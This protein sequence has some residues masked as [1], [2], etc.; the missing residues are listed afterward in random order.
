M[1]VPSDITV[2]RTLMPCPHGDVP[3][4]PRAG[5]VAAVAG[6]A[7]VVLAGVLAASLGHPAAAQAEIPVIGPVIHKIG[8]IGHTILHPVD[9]V[10]EG[11]LKILQ[12]IFGGIE[13]RLIA[14]VINALLT[15]PNFD[16]GHVAELEQTTVAIAA[17]MLTAVLTLSILR[18]YV[19]GLT[20]SGSGG[21]EALQGVVRVIGAVGFIIL[22]PGL[23][24]E[25]V[26][27]PRL[28]NEALLGSG[29]VQ[30]NVA[31]LFDAALVLGAGAFAV[32]GG[33]GLIF[34][35]LIGFIA[36]LVFIALL[37]MKVL[38]SVLLMFL[39]VTMPLAVVLWPVPELSFLATSSMKVLFVALIV[40]CVWA[41]LFALSAAINADILTWVPTHSVIDTVIV[42]PLAGITLMVLCITI[43]RFLLRTAMIGPHGQPGG[44]RM[45]RAVTIGM[46]GARAATGGARAVAGAAAEGNAGAQRMI[47]ALP[48]AVRPPSKAGEGSVAA[49][50]AFGR[51][52]FE[53]AKN[54]G[55]D[56]AGAKD[57]SARASAGT[58]GG[59]A[60]AGSGAEAAG[61]GSGAGAAGAAEAISRKR[62]SSS[63]P[64]IERPE[65][66]WSTVNNAG[67][68]MHAQSR[69]APPDAGAVAAAMATFGAETQRG[70]A[71]FNAAHPA[72][73]REFAAQHLHSGS[74]SDGQRDALMT[75][76][77]A[78]GAAVEA[79]MGQAIGSLDAQNQAR[80][81]TEVRPPSAASQPKGES[82]VAST[83]GTPRPSS[84]SPEQPSPGGGAAGPPPAAASRGSGVG[85]P[86]PPPPNPVEQPSAPAS[87][88]K[89]GLPDDPPD[90]EPFLD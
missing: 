5:R 68:E 67:K 88:P 21:F 59:A 58:P 34:V 40:P 56:G 46:L 17:G 80:A 35:I 1:P 22:W 12:A 49:R 65:F 54:A 24:N 37:W 89:R 7:S 14:G 53:K 70:L 73:L 23:F 69:I 32:D 75:I 86:P 44:G 64:G 77:S 66:D 38:L 55:G 8:G 90:L 48:A 63:V 10:M 52:G 51:S 28:F 33:I 41:I 85:Q 50:V 74:L 11:F 72:K 61:A 76:G 36:A 39:Y 3:A 42:R 13:A 57:G 9:A 27:I 31:L 16:S 2:D 87:P 84:P 79:G 47:G 4:H 78:R 60:D 83:P 26:N 18:Y 20:D 29:S 71:E 81:S 15:I 30:H 19:A 45:W 82:P 25:V 6:V 43:P 62:D